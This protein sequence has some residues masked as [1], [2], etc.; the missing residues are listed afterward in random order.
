MEPADV[1]Y[2]VIVALVLILVFAFVRAQYTHSDFEGRWTDGE[3]NMFVVER[4]GEGRLRI[5]SAADIRPRQP[6][7]P[8][9]TSRAADVRL[10]RRLCIAGGAACARLSLDGRYLKWGGGAGRRWHKN[11]VL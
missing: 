8:T 4:R 11:G 2:A 1:E 10:F 7:Q 3:G 6:G 5:L 9:I